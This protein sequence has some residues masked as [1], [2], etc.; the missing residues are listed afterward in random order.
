M[1]LED[2]FPIPAGKHVSTELCTKAGAATGKFKV[3]LDIGS[4]V[5]L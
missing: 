1:S 5:V 4:F 3:Q 2:L